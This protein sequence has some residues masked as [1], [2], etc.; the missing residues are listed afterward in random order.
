MSNQSS[1]STTCNSPNTRTN[2]KLKSKESKESKEMAAQAISYILNE[3][4][5]DNE[6][7]SIKKAVSKEVLVRENE[8]IFKGNKI[9]V[10][11]IENFLKRIIK[12]TSLE[13]STLIMSLIY[14][15]R[16]CELTSLRLNKL[17]IHRLIIIAI[18]MAIKINEDDIYAN[19]FY[20]KVGGITVE[21][22]NF[23]ELGF[24]K[25]IEYNFF[26]KEDIYEKYQ[27]YLDK[28]NDL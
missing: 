22:F 15:D 20:A 28:F 1:A 21:E 6:S 23:L 8:D 16:Y 4:I 27:A 17:N 26:V 9:P 24:T 2:N 7:T 10:I 5:N 19:S 18:Q 25:G 14:I 12:Y 11:S 3:I 13:E